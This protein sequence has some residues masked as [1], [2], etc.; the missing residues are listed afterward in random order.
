MTPS[1]TT[2]PHPGRNDVAN[3]LSYR[4]KVYNFDSSS[5]ARRLKTYNCMASQM[6]L[7]RHMEESC[8]SGPGMK[9]P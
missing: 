4:P 5:P 6:P 1:L 8:I 7:P 2:Q 3:Y 9:I